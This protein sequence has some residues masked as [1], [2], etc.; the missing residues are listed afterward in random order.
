MPASPLLTAK[1]AHKGQMR[2]NGDPYISHPVR[3]AERL[4]Q[5]VVHPDPELIAAA[6]L[7]DTL[8]DTSLHHNEIVRLYGK[9]VAFLVKSVTKKSKKYYARKNTNYLEQLA[10]SARIDPAVAFLKMADRLDNISDMAAWSQKKQSHYLK[11]SLSL[12][13]TLLK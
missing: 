10:N 5:L 8:E 4:H 2:D 9:R 13:L 3:T 6:Y 1:K 7:H 12:F 11:N